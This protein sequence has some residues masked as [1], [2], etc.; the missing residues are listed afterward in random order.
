M[1]SISDSFKDIVGRGHLRINED[2]KEV[3]VNTCLPLNFST[4]L[5]IMM[6]PLCCSRAVYENNIDYLPHEVFKGMK[7]MMSM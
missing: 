1:F 6:C 2:K 7:N 5:I 3:Y 4:F